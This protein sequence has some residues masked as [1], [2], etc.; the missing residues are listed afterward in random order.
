M[1]Q[2][3][4]E[5]IRTPGAASYDLT[6]PALQA[7]AG[8]TRLLTRNTKR[9]EVKIPPRTRDGQVVR[10]AN[11][12]RVTDGTEGDILIRVHVAA[13]PESG[14]IQVVTDATFEA[15]VLKASLPVFV[16]FWAPWCGPCRA[17]APVTEHLAAEYSGRCKFCKLNVDENPLASRK[18]QVASI[19]T[20][21]FFK[22]GRIADVSVGAAPERE[23]QARIETVLTRP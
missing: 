13:S 6:L 4:E 12:L 8:T 18:Y 17:L 1:E 11:A 2:E 22:H 15:E 14:A 5:R 7:V 9:L 3:F 10:L 20:V 21:L 23:L 16:D 19:P